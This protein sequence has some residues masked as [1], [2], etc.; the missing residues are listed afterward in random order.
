MKLNEPERLISRQQNSWQQAGQVKLCRCDVLQALRRK[1]NLWQVWIVRET[2]PSSTKAWNSSTYHRCFADGI[3]ANNEELDNHCRREICTQYET[4]SDS[5]TQGRT[6]RRADVGAGGP[7]LSSG[8]ERSNT[9]ALKGENNCQPFLET[10]H[11]MEL[12]PLGNL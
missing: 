3:K 4:K 7:Q 2:L 9:A 5:Q 8:M 6:N 11:C 1:S 10:V 12:K